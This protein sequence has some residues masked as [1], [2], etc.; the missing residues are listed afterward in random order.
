M[1][2]LLAESGEGLGIHSQAKKLCD[3]V[4]SFQ[5][6][7]SQQTKNLLATSTPLISTTK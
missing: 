4:R 3:M 6:Q 1:N 2:Q 5:L 7:N